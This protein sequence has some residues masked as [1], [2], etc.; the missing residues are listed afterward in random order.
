MSKHD[1]AP[2]T[3]ELNK[4]MREED[5]AKVQGGVTVYPLPTYPIPTLPTYPI[6]TIPTL[7]TLPALCW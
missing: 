4:E 6:P 2:S 5:L 1:N 7:P 3:P